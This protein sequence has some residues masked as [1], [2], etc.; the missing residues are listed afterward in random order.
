MMHKTLLSLALLFTWF[1]VGSTPLK[2]QEDTWPLHILSIHSYSSEYPWTRNQHDG[3]I[4]HLQE[5]LPLTTHISSEYLDTKFQILDDEY[6][7]D[8]A[9]FIL[10]KYG[11]R[12]PDALYVTDDNAYVFAKTYLHPHFADVPIFFS[13]VNDTSA[14]KQA[15]G[16]NITGVI[17]QIDVVENL[18]L[19][20]TLQ[21]NARQL[22][23][24]GDTTRTAGL[25]EKEVKRQLVD[26]AIGITLIFK[27]TAYL[28]DLLNFLKKYPDTPI[29]LTSLGALHD[30]DSRLLQ[31]KTS[32]R[33]LREATKGLILTLS[34][35]AHIEGVQAGYVTSGLRQGRAAAQLLIQWVQFGSLDLVPPLQK[36]PNEYLFNETA[37]QAIGLDIPP[38]LKGQAKITEPIPSFFERHKSLLLSLCVLISG[39]FLF[40]VF[41][42]VINMGEK[43]E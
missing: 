16:S 22:L 4:A 8:Y 41:L 36:S 13:G 17:Q 40:T 38:T 15:P 11:N 34:D 33:A 6:A 29:L 37:M 10:R 32:I 28:N 35:A 43:Y 18:M 26:K 23:V 2:A 27:Q 14:L 42:L 19:L 9:D 24:I 31:L 30:K 7:Q 20:Q 21:P 1:C 5:H 12:T 25:I 39:L 3:F